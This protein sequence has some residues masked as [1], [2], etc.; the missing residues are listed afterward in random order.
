MTSTMAWE[1]PPPNGRY[2]WAAIAAELRANPNQWL[3]VFE[4]GPIS[5]V[6][7]VRLG[8]VALQ[9][10]RPRHEDTPGFEV[11]TRNNKPGPPRT[12]DLYLRWYQ[13][14]GEE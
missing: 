13:P 4:D 11:R 6:N 3:K 5:V 14:E 8:V 1:N 2:D 10:L 12:A 9:P 7:A